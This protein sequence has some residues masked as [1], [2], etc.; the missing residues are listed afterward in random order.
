[1]YMFEYLVLYILYI[2]LSFF[3][4]GIWSFDQMFQRGTPMNRNAANV[5]V[6]RVKLRR[7]TPQSCIYVKSSK[8]YRAHATG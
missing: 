7:S 8:L 4:G 2:L 3:V 5:S 6:E 1:M